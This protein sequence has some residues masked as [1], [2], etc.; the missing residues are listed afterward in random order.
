MRFE[1]A[2]KAMRK[3]KKV[4]C[5]SLSKNIFYFARW[6]Q[7]F[8]IKECVGNS[9]PTYSFGISLILATDWEIVND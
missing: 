4:R 2:L 5:P 8:Y 6:T 1:E 7:T 9:Y 3:G